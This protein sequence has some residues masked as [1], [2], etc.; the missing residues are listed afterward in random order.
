MTGVASGRVREVAPPA[1]P[2]LMLALLALL[3]ALSVVQGIVD[4]VIPVARG[5]APFGFLFAQTERFGPAFFVAYVFLHNLGLACL[6][7]GFG[8]VA[9]RYERRT[10][11]RFLIGILL[12]GSVVVSLFVALE[13][14]LQASER[15]DL[16]TALV[17]FFAEASSI[18]A[19][20]LSATRELKGFVPTRKYEWSLVTPFRNL[21]VPLGYAVVTLVL[22]CLFEAWVVLQG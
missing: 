10:H 12:T 22:V 2:A 7:P 8:F 5:E 9:A 18:L 1:W 15:F 14:V 19:V 13:F 21:A 4:V 11:N 16:P 3:A 20:A 6:V 17:I